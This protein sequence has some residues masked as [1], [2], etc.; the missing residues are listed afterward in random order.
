GSSR[1]GSVWQIS[2]KP[3]RRRSRHALRRDA[4][5]TPQQKR[6]NGQEKKKPRQL[7]NAGDRSNIMAVD[8]ESALRRAES[9]DELARPTNEAIERELEAARGSL[10]WK[11]E[12]RDRAI[13]MT[14]AHSPELNMLLDQHAAASKSLYAIEAVLILLS[15]RDAL[16]PAVR[17]WN[18]SPEW[19]QRE[20]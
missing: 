20:F 13:A 11:T 15:R 4:P 19:H 10:R 7:I 9:D 2:N 17:G 6:S 12:H 3:N 14:I 8:G 1:R 5:L 16:P 18:S